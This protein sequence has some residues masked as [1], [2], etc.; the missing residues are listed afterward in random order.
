M[1]VPLTINFLLLLCFISLSKSE[2]IPPR[3]TYCAKNYYGPLCNN[4]CNCQDSKHLEC[5]EGPYGSGKCLCI[6]GKLCTRNKK[7]NEK[8]M[9]DRV[10]LASLNYSNEIF[11]FVQIDPIHTRHSRQTNAVALLNK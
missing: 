3:Y 9:S 7:K 4:K 5:D 2:R 6:Y 10:S 8:K 11:N 1:F